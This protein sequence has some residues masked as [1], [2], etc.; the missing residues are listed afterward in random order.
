MTRDE[1]TLYQAG[2]LSRVSTNL[3]SLSH[4]SVHFSFIV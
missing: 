1:R 4:I 2:V 3:L